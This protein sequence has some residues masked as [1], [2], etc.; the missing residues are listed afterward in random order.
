MAL[1]VPLAAQAVTAPVI[2]LL[3]PTIS[4]VGV[5]ANIVAA[6]AVAPA[7]V[8]GV[9]AAAM[10][11][12]WPT[13][14]HAVAVVSGLPAGWIAQVAR[15]GADV[16]GGSL[17]WLPGRV[18]AALLALL[19]TG[20]VVASLRRRGQ[21]R[22]DLTRPSHSATRR[23]VDVDAA[24]RSAMRAGPG[25]RRRS[26]ARAGPLL[27]QELRAHLRRQGPP[28]TPTLPWAVGLLVAVVVV[29]WA[30]GPRLLGFVDRVPVTGWAVVQCDVG[31]GDAML[32]RSGPK[33]AVLIDVGPDTRRVDRC[34]RRWG[35]ARLDAVVLTH[36]H[37]DH[38]DGL[39]GALHDRGRPQVL[40]SPCR[41]PA[42][43]FRG[44]SEVVRKAGGAITTGTAGMSGHSAGTAGVTWRLLWPPA[45]SGCQLFGGD[46]DDGVNDSS[47]VVAAE[48][49]GVSVM[50]L[51]DLETD[52][53][54]SLAASLGG[55]DRVDVV[56][57]AHHGSGKQYAPLYA[58]LRPRLALIGV[59]KGNDY[60]HPAPSTLAM[61]GRL[62][63]MALRTDEQG[64]LAVTGP[65]DRLA[66]VTGSRR[67][68]HTSSAAR[69]PP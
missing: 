8:G 1:A 17:P 26:Q 46:A 24:L 62:P 42:A 6:P 69:G 16:P 27:P 30:V 53:Q 57:V 60:G 49:D 3:Q 34:L 13:G 51:G 50:A 56:K 10:S 52:A 63:V 48:V 11:P 47:L 55:I 37:A 22:N 28:R 32:L 54:R 4:L 29:G 7:T 43:G 19:V 36:F 59:G 58:R 20:A 5:P 15:H 44:V 2:V 12:A 64:D 39:A 31:Q 9:L 41:Q 25:R 40:V 23:R 14:A 18:G 61:L 35:V 45:G 38:V 33:R 66:A 65:A 68:R 67:R 21:P